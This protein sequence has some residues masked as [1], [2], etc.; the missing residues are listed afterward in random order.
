MRV[1]VCGCLDGSC[2]YSH[3]VNSFYTLVYVSVSQCFDYVWFVVW[4]VRVR[5]WGRVRVCVIITRTRT[6]ARTHT[7]YCLFAI[8][9]INKA[10][11]K[12]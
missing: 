2:H 9:S 6:H 12:Y 11:I 5:A 7:Q 1:G 4:C 10:F 8:M 3:S